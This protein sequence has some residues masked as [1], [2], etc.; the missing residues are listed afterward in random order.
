MPLAASAAG[1]CV[2][3]RLRRLYNHVACRLDRSSLTEETRR[4][5]DL[6][7]AVEPKSAL[8]ALALGRRLVERLDRRARL[9]KI[10]A[11]AGTLANGSAQRWEYLFDLAAARA[12]AELVWSLV[13]DESLDRWVGARVELIARPFVPRGGTLWKLLEEGKLLYP[14][15]AGLWRQELGRTS[16]LPRRIRDSTEV[17]PALIRAGLR[18]EEVEFSLTTEVKPPVE[19]RWVAHT[20]REAYFVPL[21]PAG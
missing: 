18:P 17:L 12:R 9:T 5:L 2:S 8:E 7:A 13:W 14:Q 6:G 1:V 4:E 15:I 21:A 11:P 16:P 10:A 19:P 20:R 3:D